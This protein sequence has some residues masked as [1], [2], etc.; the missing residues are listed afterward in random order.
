MTGPN[1][2]K[3]QKVIPGPIEPAR[4]AVPSMQSTYGAATPHS[5]QTRD[6]SANQ[7]ATHRVTLYLF[8]ASFVVFSVSPVTILMDSQFELLTSESLLR[9]HSVALNRFMIPGLDPQSLPVHPDSEVD[10]PFY[11]LVRV[12]GEVVYRYPHGGSFLA[13]PFVALMDLAGASVVRRDR[14]YDATTEVLSGKLLASLLM[15]VL[16]A[17]LFEIAA[18]LVPL[19]FALAIAVT[20][21]F[22]SQ[23]WSSTSRALWSQT[24]EIFIAGWVIWLLLSAEQRGS[25]QGPKRL[26]PLLLATLLAWL[27]FVRPTGAI[28]VGCVTLFVWCYHRRDFPAFALCGA[29]WGAAFILYSLWSF[30]QPIPDYY[31]WSGRISSAHQMAATLMACLI[32]PSRGLLVFTP[33]VALPLYLVMRHCRDLAHSGMAILSLAII[34]CYMATVCAYSKWWGGYSFGPR[35]LGSLVPWWGLLAALGFQALLRYGALP[36]AGRARSV[37]RRLVVTF[38]LMAALIGIVINGWG[39]ISWAPLLW[40]QTVEIDRHPE[41]VWDWHNAQ[42]AVGWTGSPR[43]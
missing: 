42:F 26:R 2:P 43:R 21:G 29:A 24:W 9:D 1:R 28:V 41:R 22:G 19:P 38:A 23:I 25:V 10:R 32:S 20:A 40:N 16:V 12:G 39:A 13:L 3:A 36:G 33:A 7:P 5:R 11:Q 17:L 35:L 34:A 30:G 4:S 37:Y 18:R 31:F 8:L 6:A 27:F 15:A 14:S